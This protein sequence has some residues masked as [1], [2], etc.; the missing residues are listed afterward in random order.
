MSYKNKAEPKSINQVYG[1]V[2]RIL[3]G[4]TGGPLSNSDGEEMERL[5]PFSVPSKTQAKGAAAEQAAEGRES[6]QKVAESEEGKDETRDAA[7]DKAVRSP[8]KDASRTTRTPLSPTRSQT[9]SEMHQ[10]ER[11]A[12]VTMLIETNNRLKEKMLELV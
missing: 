6:E 12:Q 8:W 7:K 5:D 4:H 11:G 9:N 3:R 10:D 2:A 1:E